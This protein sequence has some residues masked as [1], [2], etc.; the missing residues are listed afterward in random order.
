ML[1]ASVFPVDTNELELLFAAVDKLCLNDS[2]I[3]VVR[4]LSASL[5]AGLRCGFLGFLHMEVVIQRLRDEFNVDVVMTTPSVPYLIE[6]HDGTKKEISCVSD[7]PVS[8]TGI[9]N[10]PFVVSEPIVKVYVRTFPISLLFQL[11]PPS[12]PPFPSTNALI[13]TGDI[14]NPPR[15][16][17]SDGRRGKGTQRGK[18]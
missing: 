13:T 2:S 5:G 9:K 8:A 11:P 3:S 16:L 7:W 17:W 18:Y 10:A 4:D 6:Y 14:N 15:L 1:F 12:L